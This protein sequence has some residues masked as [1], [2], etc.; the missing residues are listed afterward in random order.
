MS[1]NF[2][3]KPTL[4]G[5]AAAVVLLA[6]APAAYAQNKCSATGQMGGEKFALTQCVAAVYE[7][8]I[9]I[10]FNEAPIAAAEAQSFAESS[11]AEE[12][13]DGKPRT[14]AVIMFCPGGG[15]ATAS[16]SAVKS[17]DLHTNHAKS[18]FLGVQTVV[19]APKDLKV[20]KLSG[21]VKPGGSVAGKMSGSSGETKFNFDFD[22]KLPE[23]ESAAGMGCQ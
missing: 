5:F 10:W 18:A 21:E 23:K 14:L 2:A 17:I 11:S 9:A 15:A 19:E 7:H 16:A 20:E 6:L 13:K 3:A 1:L 22:V 8:S 4:Q 12:K